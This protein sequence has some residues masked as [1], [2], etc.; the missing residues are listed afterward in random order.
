VLA[1][2]VT[3]AA[4]APSV[5]L[6]AAGSGTSTTPSGGAAPG[7][8]A[9]SQS[10]P[11]VPPPPA[12]NAHGA[13]VRSITIT[14]YWPAPES[15]FRGKLVSAPGLPGRHRID[16]LY[17]AEGVSMEGEGYGLDGLQYH[18]DALGDGGWVTKSGRPTS[19]GDGFAQGSPYWRA[20]DFWRGPG[21]VVTFPLQSGGWANGVGGRYVP[22]P[23]VTFAPGSSL[24]IH[25][26]QSI[27]V[28]PRVIPLGSRVYIP[29]YR[30]DG[31]GGWFVAQDTGGAIVGHRIDVYRRPPRSPTD[32]GQYLKGQSAFVIKPHG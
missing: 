3:L 4:V 22:L 28:D 26:Y 19:A 17:S 21:G 18:I 1:L 13:W 7:A 8:L 30:H 23:G 14:E 32:G 12:K 16:W 6:A 5:A 20:G 15:W 27:A 29:A 10:H 31:H 9:P 24:P 11:I 2:A 25:F